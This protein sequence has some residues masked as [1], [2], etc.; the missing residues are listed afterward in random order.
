[1]KNKLLGV[2]A[3]QSPFKSHFNLESRVSKSSKIK[4]NSQFYP[5]IIES[6]FLFKDCDCPYLQYI[7]VNLESHSC[8][9]SPSSSSFSICARGSALRT[10]N[11]CSCRVAAEYSST[12]VTL[13]I[14]TTCMSIKTVS[15]I[16]GSKLKVY[17][18]PIIFIAE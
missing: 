12:P 8:P 5:V 17:F 18:D 11:P 3:Y 10:P 9:S 2:S 6:S 15:Y 7:L 13:G 14:H 4:N 1:M 16:C